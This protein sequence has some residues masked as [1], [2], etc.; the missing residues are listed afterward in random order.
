MILNS[1]EKTLM[2]N[3]IRAALKRRFETP[4]LEELGGRVEGECVLEM[5]C[6]RG[7][8]TEIVLSRFGA[9]HV[10]A[11]DLD[12]DMVE[13]ARRGSATGFAWLRVMRVGSPQTPQVTTPSLTSAS[14]TTCKKQ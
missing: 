3:P 9:A 1:F 11:F 10:D 2:N 7:V 12:S 14:F 8:G 4:L 5:G 6:G 13:R